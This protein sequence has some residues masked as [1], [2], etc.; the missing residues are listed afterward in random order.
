EMKSLMPKKIGF[1]KI[2]T[3][4]SWG[5]WGNAFT[6]SDDN[7]TLGVTT[8]EGV[9]IERKWGLDIPIAL[10]IDPLTAAM[11][12]I[13][14]FVGWLV[15]IYSIG[16]MHGEL[17]YLRYFIYVSLFVFSM[18]ILVSASN[19]VLLY[20]AW[21]GVGVCSY[22][23]IGYWFTRPSAANASMKAFLMNRVG[24]VGLALA[25]FLIWI[26]CGT[27]NFH[28][29]GDV[30]GVFGAERLHTTQPISATVATATAICLLL[31]LGACGKSAQFPLHTWLPD[32]MEGPTPASALIHAATMV[33]AG[34]YLV[35]R[36]A[37]FFI[38]SQ[39]KE[40]PS[41]AFAVAAI[42]GFTALLAALIALTQTDL[43]R[44]LAYSTV[45]QLGYMFLAA[46]A[47]TVAGATAGMFHLFTH[48]WFKALLF[49]GAG[50][51]M[52]Q[53]GHVIDMRRFGGLRRVMP[54]TAML[55][56]IGSVAL[57]GLPPLAGFFS[58]DAVLAAVYE[59]YV[60]HSE[61]PANPLGPLYHALYWGGIFTAFLTAF[62]TFRAFF[63]T[64]YGKTTVPPEAIEHAEHMA[65][66]AAGHHGHGHDDHDGHGHDDHAHDDHVDHNAAPRPSVVPKEG[67][68]F[69]APYVM[70]FP[71]ILLAVGTCLVGM[72]GDQI[73][74]FLAATPTLTW[75]SYRE[76]V[77]HHL[78]EIQHEQIHNFVLG[79]SVLAAGLGVAVAAFFYLGDR[80]E[81]AWLG[82]FSVSQSLQRI[83][84]SKFYIDEAWAALFV[85]PTRAL[86]AISAFFDRWILDGL[87]DLV[88]KTPAYLAQ[89][90]RWTGTGLIPYHALAM[91]M[92]VLALIL[93]AGLLY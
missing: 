26:N 31:L 93:A 59:Q 37:P 18:T 69:E 63:L 2:I 17:G 30:P 10:R 41:A 1:E 57:A 11:L 35:V 79:C 20:A 12:S 81:I 52:L 55:F 42:G 22:L 50:A 68:T 15:V 4:W 83:S 44:V 66:E 19:F 16:Y 51:V 67:Q 74:E 85:W 72:F 45:S 29:V 88:G 58:K 56:F 60:V 76:S 75:I 33:T 71:M 5:N 28:D 32:A 43:K 34:V 73:R 77:G 78:S 87:V 54:L 53:M 49:L 21:E 84:Y 82:K 13:I 3:L 27:L 25:I 62:Y 64:F 38:V 48:A 23:L 39:M 80:K 6:P 14:T 9:R 24:D 92:G 61:D 86:A 46:G 47:G 90:I 7:P 91:V 8:N 89:T 70:V 40:G 36:C 65:H